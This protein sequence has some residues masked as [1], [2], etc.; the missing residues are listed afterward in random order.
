MK[1]AE[2]LTDRQKEEVRSLIKHNR[3]VFSE[4]PG[5]T[6]AIFHDVT[7]PGKRVHVRTDRVPKARRK[8]ID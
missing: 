2:D 7:V 3:H 1:I 8:N 4:L 5:R 6:T